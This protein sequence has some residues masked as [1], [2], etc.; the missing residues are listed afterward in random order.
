MF[1]YKTIS[2]FCSY[3]SFVI[4]IVE[5]IPKKVLGSDILAQH[6]SQ[7]GN[8]HASDE[9]VEEGKDEKSDAEDS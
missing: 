6:Q 7:N 1:H 9:E 8:G 4:I 2:I 5:I 3:I